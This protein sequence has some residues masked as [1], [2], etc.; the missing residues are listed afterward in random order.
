MARQREI[1][2]TTTKKAGKTL[3]NDFSRK[4]HVKSVNESRK[5]HPAKLYLN[6]IYFW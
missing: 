6:E 4:F 1:K 5:N 2:T 3:K